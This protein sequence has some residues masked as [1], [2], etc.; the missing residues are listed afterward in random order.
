[1]LLAENGKTV[2]DWVKHVEDQESVNH[3][4]CSLK[5]EE[6]FV[7]PFT[8]QEEIPVIEALDGQLITNRLTAKPKVLNNSIISDLENDVLKMVVVNRYHDAP[9]AVSFVKNF[10]LKKEPL[11]Q[12]LLTIVII[13]LLL[14]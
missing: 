12:A 13:L 7:Y 1:M 6:D 10:G 14:V 9:V 5:K 11:L 2:G 8:G 4:D 3:F